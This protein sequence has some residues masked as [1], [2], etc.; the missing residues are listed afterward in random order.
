MQF[1]TDEQD[2][3]GTKASGLASFNQN[4]S[5]REICKANFKSRG[6]SEAVPGDM[7]AETEVDPG[8]TQL[9]KGTFL[10]VLPVGSPWFGLLLR[11][12]AIFGLLRSIL[13]QNL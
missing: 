12:V 2:G 4:P 6:K 7:I 3:P 13:S 5:L 8:A 11:I 10:L 1:L 9:D